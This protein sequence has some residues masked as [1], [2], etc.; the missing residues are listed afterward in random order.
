M[1][2]QLKRKNGRKVLG[3]FNSYE[4]A[5]NAARKEIRQLVH[6]TNEKFGY[7]DRVS[8]GPTKVTGLFKIV[9]AELV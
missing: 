5:R 8:R 9:K 4:E 6:S 1:I 7:Y 3:Q 2:Y